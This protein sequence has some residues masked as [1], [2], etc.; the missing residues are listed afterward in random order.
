MKKSVSFE[1]VYN[2]YFT[3]LVRYFQFKT[4]SKPDSEEL[5]NDVLI[6][7]FTHLN[8]FDSEKSALETWIFNISKNT[9][10]DYFRS[11][12]ATIKGNAMKYQI[13]TDSTVD[14]E[15]FQVF[16]VPDK[17]IKADSLHDNAILSN[18]IKTALNGLKPAHKA[19]AVAFFVDELKLSEIVEK[20][21]LPL[22]TVKGT[23][24]RIREKLQSQLVN[25]YEMVC[26]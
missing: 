8:D 19:I 12:N 16:Q 10:I 4:Q 6:K 5:A 9:L 7:V 26:G 24:N 11:K 1:V 18:S 2:E 14:E 23:I 25:E 13:S 20:L 15:F 17:G 21:E 3:K 22:G